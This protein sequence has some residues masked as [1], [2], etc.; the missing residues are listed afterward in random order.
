MREE[1]STGVRPPRAFDGLVNK[2]GFHFVH[3]GKPTNVN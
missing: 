1:A 2:F 3:K